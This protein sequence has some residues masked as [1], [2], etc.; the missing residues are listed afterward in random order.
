M[1]S[2]NVVPFTALATADL[3]ID[4]IYEGGSAGSAADDPIN[5]LL[6]GVGNMGGFRAAGRGAGKRLVAL[7]TSGEDRDW[8]DLLDSATSRF[9]YYGDNKK[10]GHELHDTPR[11]GN[12]LLRHV[13]GLLHCGAQIDIPPFLI[14]EKCPTEKSGRSVRFRGL[15]IP[16]F[17]GR[18]ATEDLVAVWK[19]SEGQRFQNYHATF[20]VLDIATIPRPWLNALL[21][22]EQPREQLPVWQ[23]WQEDA[24]YRPLEAAATTHIRSIE[25]QTPNTKNEI[26]I[27]EA[28]H[29]HFCDRPHAFEDFA[30]WLYRL[31]DE[32]VVI[33]EVTRNSVD[34][35]RDAIGRYRLGLDSDPVFVDFAL[36]AKCYQPPLNG[37]RGNTV[38]VREVA[39]LVSRLRHRQFGALVTTSVVARQTYDEVRSDGHPIIFI[40]GRDIA[41]ILIRQGYQSLKSVE[42]L[43]ANEFPK[44]LS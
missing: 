11:G 13:F 16:G 10:P 36:E 19:H 43:L 3:T 29:Q 2:T 40:C 27:L 41:Q 38:G 7:Y 5:K 24:I 17:V 22:G 15:A 23:R 26:A 30:A 4:A 31:H 25:E 33:D 39:R 34:G 35:G 18:S 12:A 37:K 14:F 42:N 32:R 6:P 8:P 1:P 28:V 44:E 9:T 21:T 20:T